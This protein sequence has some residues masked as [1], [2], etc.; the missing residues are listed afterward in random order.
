M[1]DVG[2]GFV[3]ADSNFAQCH[4]WLMRPNGHHRP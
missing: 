3:G 2:H 4:E 1:G